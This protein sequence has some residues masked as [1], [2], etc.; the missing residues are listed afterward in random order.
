MNSEHPLIKLD[1]D[2]SMEDLQSRITELTKKLTIAHRLGNRHLADQ[3]RMAL[4]S[5][6]TAYQDRLRAQQEAQKN[7]GPDYSDRID[8]S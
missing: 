1:P 6:Q 3:V 7:D 2:A 4:A 8:I 5:Y